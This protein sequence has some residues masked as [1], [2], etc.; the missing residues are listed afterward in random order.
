MREGVP[1][2]MRA[3]RAAPSDNMACFHIGDI[4]VSELLRTLL[5]G[6]L[7]EDLILY[8]PELG[9]EDPEDQLR[10]GQNLD[11]HY[12]LHAWISQIPPS[13]SPGPYT[14]DSLP[15]LIFYGSVLN[16][17]PSRDMKVHSPQVRA[18]SSEG[19]RN[20]VAM[21]PETPRTSLLWE[22]DDGGD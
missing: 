9:V 12:L 14:R 1:E 10:W 6:P 16:G 7:Q 11:A 8:V 20:G 22:P 4:K 2:M 17:Q 13:V 21:T 18:P 3:L 5:S 19:V 15:Q